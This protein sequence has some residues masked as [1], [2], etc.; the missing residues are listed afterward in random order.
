MAKL[1]FISSFRS[2]EHG[3]V[4]VEADSVSRTVIHSVTPAEALHLYTRIIDINGK[5]DYFVVNGNLCAF[6]YESERKEM[7]A[8]YN[9]DTCKFKI[10][11]FF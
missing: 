3:H 11:R 8:S 1:N 5:P 9:T 4:S 7:M 10:Y 6:M 2:V